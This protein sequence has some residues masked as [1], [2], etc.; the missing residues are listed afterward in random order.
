MQ[1]KTYTIVKISLLSVIAIALVGLLS[2]LLVGG[3]RYHWKWNFKKE[4]NRIYEQTYSVLE[5]EQINVDVKSTDIT[6]KP[7]QDDKVHITIYGEKEEEATSIL[8]NNQLTIT[9]N[10]KN[11]FCFGFCFV[12]NNEIVLSIPT[13]IN[14][15]LNFKTTSGDIWV[16]DLKNVVLNA[17]TSSGE[18]EF[19]TVRSA[20]LK[21]QSGDVEGENMEHA[22]VYTSSGDIHLASTIGHVDLKTSSG[23]I[24]LNDFQILE[25]SSIQTS[26]GDVTISN[27]TDCYINGKTRS[28]D[29]HI[30]ETNRFSEIELQI[31]TSSGD[32]TVK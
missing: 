1:N 8:E 9:K 16:D 10:S 24:K 7:S 31:E 23:D 25:S 2:F 17:E 4:Q 15:T 20:N 3:T 13:E 22:I 19:G 18:I 30:K 26:S 11:H 5:L 32:I 12:N 14:T 29:T 6:V 28:G 21:T 27:I